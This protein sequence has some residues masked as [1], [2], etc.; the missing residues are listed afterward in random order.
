MSEEKRYFEEITPKLI[1]E[2]GVVSLAIRPNQKSQYGTGGLSGKELQQRFDKLATLIISR[3]NEVA[4]ALSSKEVLEYFKLPNETTLADFI[5]K[6]TDDAYDIVSTNPY[7]KGNE[8]K[9]S[10]IIQRLFAGIEALATFTE[11]DETK[12]QTISE[13]YATITE[14][15]DEA[16]A[17]E[18]SDSELATLISNAIKS[19]E[20]DISTAVTKHNDAD[21][22]HEDIRN[23]LNNLKAIV[24]NFFSDVSDG[25]KDPIDRLAEIVYYLNENR[26]LID[27][28][29]NDRVEKANIV[30]SVESLET[31]GDTK[32][33]SAKLLYDYFA[34]KEALADFITIT[35]LTEALTAALLPYAKNIRLG[36]S[37]KYFITTYQHTQSD[38]NGWI[39][40]T[41]T[42]SIPN[43]QSVEGVES[44]D[45]LLFRC[46]N[47]TT[48]LYSYVF[49]TAVETYPDTNKIVALS[50]SVIHAGASTSSGGI[51]ASSIVTNLDDPSTDKVLAA[52]VGALI[53]ERIEEAVAGLLSENEL[54]K[55]LEGYVTDDELEIAVGDMLTKKDLDLALEDV[56]KKEEIQGLVKST[57][58]DKTLANY[59]LTTEVHTI[60]EDKIQEALETFDPGFNLPEAATDIF[61]E[62][63][64]TNGS[65]GLKYGLEDENAKCLGIG[66]CTNTD[67]VIGS[68]VKGLPVVG[69]Y[70]DAFAEND[71]IH[72]TYIPKS[73]ETVEANAFLNCTNLID[74]YYH[75]DEQQWKDMFIGDGNEHFSNA[76]SFYLSS[77]NPLPTW[78]YFNRYWRYDDNQTI[79]EVL[80]HTEGLTMVQNSNGTWGVSGIGTN[81]S[82]TL[83][84]IPYKHNGGLVTNINNNAFLSNKNLS[85]CIIPNSVESIGISAFSG[86]NKL[87]R[88]IIGKGVKTIGTGSFASPTSG[89]ANKLFVY[90]VG[91]QEEWNRIN[92]EPNNARLS[93]AMFQFEVT[94]ADLPDLLEV[95]E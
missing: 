63:F 6:I 50:T 72:S 75:G 14:L 70:Q 23:T 59:A 57:D 53:K 85:I 25:D 39:D 16:S 68:I 35:T 45:L 78:Q 52:S 88:V 95:D 8:A 79:Q 5:E 13:I 67:I 91:T 89:S 65:F 74:V 11:Y 83:I 36:G 48:N 92:I 21:D 41:D 80:N 54:E 26:D 12:E 76:V 81:T 56:A 1:A 9:L 61:A 31:A 71:R 90:Y 77:G 46:F 58:L 29:K 51:D 66:R 17:R 94:P 42:W 28:L 84:K 38:I 86:C 10:T 64:L 20:T 93:G 30:T 43:E 18:S 32:I 40:K 3:Y 69:I 47:T 7:D 82:A 60:A 4:K 44:G 73:I 15:E 37:L 55:A 62:V 33:A 34:T 24:E 27:E 2:N 49:A 19:L 87:S 22:N